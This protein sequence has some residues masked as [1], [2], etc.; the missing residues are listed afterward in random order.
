MVIGDDCAAVVDVD[1]DPDGFCD[2]GLAKLAQNI[3]D[4][5]I[6][7]PN[8]NHDYFTVGFSGGQNIYQ[9]QVERFSLPHAGHV[10]WNDK[11]EWW[12]ILAY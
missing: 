3:K 2:L 8:M 5:F 12:Q 10:E 11:H 4:Y 9:D 7:R 1:V 6:Y